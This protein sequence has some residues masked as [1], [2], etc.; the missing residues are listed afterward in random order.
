MEWGEGENQ[1]KEK[2]YVIYKN[3]IALNIYVVEDVEDIVGL[4]SFIIISYSGLEQV[5]CKMERENYYNS[6]QWVKSVAVRM[7]KRRQI[8]EIPKSWNQWDLAYDLMNMKSK[9]SE[10]TSQRLGE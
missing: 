5:E 9:E 1:G 8:W 7:E 10:V 2:N 4:N 6:S 3:I